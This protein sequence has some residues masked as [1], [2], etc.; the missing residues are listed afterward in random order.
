[1]EK[2][3]KKTIKEIAGDLD[4]GMKCHYN[5]KTGQLISIPD[6]EAYGEAPEDDLWQEQFDA[7]EKDSDNF[8]TLEQMPSWKSYKIM[9]DFI[10]Q[11]DDKNL[12]VKLEDAIQK[13]KPFRNFGYVIDDAGDYRDQWFAYKNKRYCDWVA[14]QFEVK[15]FE[16]GEE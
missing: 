13:K 16:Y 5:T 8:V 14:S 4:V 11:I 12:Q 3:D 9:E 1:M 7:I 15:N 6:F 2:P 10:G